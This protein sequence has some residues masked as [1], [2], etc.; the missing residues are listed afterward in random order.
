M[1]NT[2]DAIRRIEASMRILDDRMHRAAGD[3]DYETCLHEKRTLMTALHALREKRARE[4]AGT[5]FS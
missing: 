2:T 4:E 5:G 1:Q 3:L